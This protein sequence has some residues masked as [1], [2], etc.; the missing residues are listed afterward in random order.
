[1]L[2]IALPKGRLCDDAVSKLVAVGLAPQGIIDDSRKLIFRDEEYGLC[3]YLA[4]P[5][6]VGVY[7]ERGVADIGIVGKDVLLEQQPNVYELLDL[8][9]GTCSM[10]VASKPDFYDDPNR[11]L[12]VATK[13]VRIAQEYYASINRDIDVIPLSGSI[14]LGPVIGLSDVIVDITQT[15]TTLR[16]N[17]LVV[18]STLFDVSARLIANK[19]NY[20]FKRAQI[21]R[22]V[23]VLAS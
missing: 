11:P 9:F 23:Q 20:E 7:V 3:F 6:D 4:K 22:I 17:G 13:Y 16:E 12:R 5:A 1:M 10:M 18:L 8:G 21:D 2:N 19:S 15:G 14:E